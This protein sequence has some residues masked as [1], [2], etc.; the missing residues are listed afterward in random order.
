MSRH[1]ASPS[2]VHA[3]GHPNPWGLRLKVLLGVLVLVGVL[4]L[5]HFSEF[6]WQEVP[7]LLER[8]NRPLALL[9][10]ATLPIVGFPISAVYLAAGAI[11]GPWLGGVVVTGVTLVHVLVTHV[12]ART[13]L[14][15]RIEH[16]RKKWNRRVP[17]VPDGE[18]GTLVAMLVIVP[19]LPYLA[20]NCL[21]A[22]S[23][24]PLRYL[25][26]LAVPLYVARSYV[27]IFLGDLGNDPST[28]ALVI[29]GG[30]FVTKLAISAL[31]FQR[32]RHRVRRK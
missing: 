23:D 15:H 30:V 12:L 32:L 22:L 8:V 26:G 24:V 21:L 3:G 13:L 19:G 25:L 9:M 6:E 10:M 2:A 27:T 17:Q 18:Y 29:L 11:F 5:L 31:L 16:W 28:R 1:S 20:R 7:A 14:R 4:A